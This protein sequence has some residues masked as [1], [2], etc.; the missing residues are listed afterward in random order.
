VLMARVAM[1]RIGG[2]TGD[3]YGAI[4]EITEVVILIVVATVCSSPALAYN[5]FL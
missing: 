2:L 4:C 1:A 3:V 5:P